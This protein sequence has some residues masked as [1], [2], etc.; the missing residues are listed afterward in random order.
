M[1]DVEN[2][3]K[4]YG[5]RVAVRAVSFR[6]E[7]G[8]VIGFLGPNGAGKSTTLRMLTGYLTP[9]DGRIRIGDVDAV[10]DPVAAR[11]AIG[12][13]PE[14]VPLY[15]DM[16]VHEYLSYRARLKGVPR[17]RVSARVDD[18]L[19]RA[20]V[21]D[22]RDRIIGQ[23]SKGYRSRV[24]LADAMVADP[25][26]LILDEPTAGLDPNQI[27][28]VR[29]L[30]RSM[31][32]DKTV[33]L[34]THILPEVETTCGRVLIIN[35]G[36]LVGE[37]QPG[38]LRRAG[39]GAQLLSLEARADR[40]RLERAVEAVT[41]V[42]AIT[43]AQVME[44]SGDGA[45]SIVRLRVEADPGDVAERIFA[46]VAEAGLRLRELRREQASLEEVFTQL[47]TQDRAE[48]EGVPEADGEPAAPEQQGPESESESDE[49]P[50]SDARDGRDGDG[51]EE[52]S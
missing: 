29:E 52:P 25:P 15:R 32:G 11:R 50:S 30:I 40:E 35:K 16:R 14:S 36:R 19:G 20:N 34:S 5:E 23:L 47:T 45:D 39:G 7:P 37:G 3:T 51:E 38:E 49:A 48:S 2:L 43:D 42:R 46:A 33:L 24:G 1:I 12:Y 9:N 28:Q 4:H 44:A 8:E 6:V 13:M 31:A 27:R 10:A 18:A 21:G 17:S 41:G 26:L 22:V